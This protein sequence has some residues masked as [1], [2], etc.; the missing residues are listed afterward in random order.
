MAE[1][2]VTVVTSTFSRA[3][4]LEETIRSVRAQTLTDFEHLITSDGGTEEV[5]AV[6][7]RARQADARIRFLDWP[8]RGLFRTL[9][10][11]FREARGKYV[12][13]I[14]DDDLWTAAFLNRLVSL[15]QG[16]PQQYVFVSSDY[17][18]LR[19]DA[20]SEPQCPYALDR[21]RHRSGVVTAFINS[22]FSKA[23]LDALARK[24]GFYF[25][26]HLRRLADEDLFLALLQTGV[27]T[28]HLHETLAYYR[29]HPGQFARKPYLWAI[30]DEATVAARAGRPMRPMETLREIAWLVNLNLGG[31]LSQARA[32]MSR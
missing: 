29:E 12:A 26:P 13:V 17:A 25:D 11:A 30:L 2:T 21:P 10:A 9:D 3:T 31:R 32:K 14:A 24:R 7:E 28:T 6:G 16:N 18:F 5:R 27:P 19:G 23:H 15:F 4:L 1:P 8:H 20:L 22:V